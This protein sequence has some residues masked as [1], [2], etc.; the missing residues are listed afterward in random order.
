MGMKTSGAVFQRLMDSVLEDLQPKIAEVYIDDITIFSLTLEQHHKD[1]DCVLER[2]SAANQKV[3]V[4][5]CAFACE[6]LFLL[7]FKVFKDGINPNPVKV[8]E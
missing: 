3:N 7:V 6:E 1:E 2:L 8:Q 4:N 5:K